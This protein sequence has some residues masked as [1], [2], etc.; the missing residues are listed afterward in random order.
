MRY[1][2]IFVL[3]FII[4]I[5]GVLVYYYAD[6]RFQAYK[7]IHYDPPLS[8]MIYD[9][10]GKLIA[11][12]F[13]KE[14]RRFVE[15]NDIPPRII[16]ALVAMEDT[17]FFEH[18]GINFEAIFRAIIKDI[19]AMK[20]VEGASTITQQLVKNSVLT[21]E[22]TIVRKLKE[23]VLSYKLEQDLTKEE[24]LERY[25][26]HIYFGHG[27][28]GIKTAANGYFRKS[29]D[30]LSLKEIAILIGLPRAPSFY[31]PTRHL[32]LSLSRAN[33]VLFR[34]KNLG[35][36]SSEEYEEAQSSTPI[37][38]DDTLTQNRAPY[39]VDTILKKLTKEFEDIKSGGYEIHLTIDL[40]LQEHAKK[41]LLLGYDLIK[42]RDDQNKTSATLNG[43]LVSIDHST[44][45]VLSLVGGIDYKKSNFN[46]ATQSKRQPGSSFKPFIYQI[47]LDLGMSPLSKVA[48]I[49]RIYDIPESEEDWKP[50]NYEENYEGLLTLQEALIHSRNL[51]TINLVSEIGLDSIYKEIS[52]FGFK[53]VPYDLSISLGSFGV[54]PLELSKFYTIFS[55][56]GTMIEPYMI[57]S[58]KDRYG[59]IKNY[60]TTSRQLIS[61]QQ[62][63]LLTS[64]L[65]KVVKRGTGKKARVD[66]L[67]IAGKTGTTNDNI[68]AWFCGFSP[69]IQTIVWFGN[70]DNTPMKRYETGGRAAGPVFESFMSYYLSKNPG[71]KREFNVPNGVFEMTIGGEKVHFS[72]VSKPP[73][74]DV[75][76]QEEKLIF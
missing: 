43:A 27:Y 37:V 26:N 61:E 68:D 56:H 62:S 53:K 9:R 36:I 60:G 55:N 39:V 15:Y 18:N 52:R 22:K 59:Q 25:L 14:H 33:K 64:I 54:S 71:T 8:S 32:D 38:Y 13:E 76:T 42:K 5:F 58:I 17:A 2:L 75:K 28:Y 57:S 66:G 69:Q 7:I 4:S 23:V 6:V 30:E 16:E 29:L 21:R 65:Q 19:K 12:L 49:S 34:M 31:D 20:F 70:D 63:Y 47:A 46:R 67:Q 72:D 24:I 35:W 74:V 41:D 1:F 50:K 10:N 48:D 51:A 11:N 3:L 45:E 40:D 73:S 44:G